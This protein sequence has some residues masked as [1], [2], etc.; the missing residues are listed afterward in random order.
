MLSPDAS[1]AK[2][3]DQAYLSRES[4]LQLTSLLEQMWAGGNHDN[5]LQ[6]SVDGCKG[7]RHGAVTTS[8]SGRSR[9]GKKLV[10]VEVA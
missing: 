5:L 2:I 7:D 10:P 9:R 3:A 8:K 1:D 6:T 4:L